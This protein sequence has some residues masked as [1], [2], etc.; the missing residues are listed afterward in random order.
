MKEIHLRNA[1]LKLTHQSDKAFVKDILRFLMLPETFQ[2]KESFTKI[3]YNVIK[4]DKEALGSELQPRYKDMLFLLKTGQ[5]ELFEMFI[6]R[7]LDYL[8]VEESTSPWGLNIP[9]LNKLSDATTIGVT[10]WDVLK[11]A[12]MKGNF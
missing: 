7:L 9:D 1:Q 12:V 8:I 6:N 5:P 11:Y 10:K 2:D 4:A 3:Q